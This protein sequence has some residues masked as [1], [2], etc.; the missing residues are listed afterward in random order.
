MGDMTPAA[1]TRTGIVGRTI[2]AAMRGFR[3]PASRPTPGAAYMRNEQMPMFFRWHPALRDS[4]DDVK[5]AWRLATARSIDVIQNNGFLAGAIEQSC[6]SVVGLG[7][8]LNAK[9]NA[10]ALGWTQEQANAWS[11]HVEMRFSLWTENARACDAGGRFTFGQILAQAYRHWMATGEILATLPWIRKAGTQFGTKIKLLPAWRLSTDSELPDLCSGV[12]LDAVGGPRAYRLKFKNGYGGED[13]IEV[14][15]E[16]AYGRPLVVHIFDGEPDQVRGISPFTSVLKVTRQ[17]DQLADATLTTTLIQTIFAAMFKSAAPTEEVLEA[18]KSTAEQ[19]DPG[20]AGMLSAKADW[21]K[22]TDINLGQ[23]GKILHGFP[24][25]ELQFFRTEHPNASY[26]PFA[27]FLLRECSRAAAMT[28]EEFTGDYKGAT[29]T[30]NKMGTTVIW[31]RVLYRR[32]HI[33]APLAQRAYEAW[34]EEDIESGGT[35]YPGGVPAF[36]AQREAACQAFWLGPTKP[37]ADDEKSAKAAKIKQEIGLPDA[38]VFEEYGIDP[39]DAYEQAKREQD[40]REE[41]GLKPRIAAPVAA[42]GAGAGREEEDSADEESE[43][44]DEVSEREEA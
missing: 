32:R 40:R 22:Q 30:S 2:D 41:L 14:A 6:G 34:L 12:R 31:P 20:I 15:A 3:A 8:R 37:Q 35:P 25:D 9:P 26:E 19:T 18:M 13:Q 7:L 38:V 24:G 28:Y 11:R 42:P 1:L 16:D 29:F 27:K 33:V 17:F 10:V 43:Q 44:G 23:H 39:D 5:A 4:S 21:Y 36:L